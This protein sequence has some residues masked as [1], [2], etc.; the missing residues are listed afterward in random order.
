M[1]RTAPSACRGLFVDSGGVGC[2][3]SEECGRLSANTLYA[4]PTPRSSVIDLPL[5]VLWDAISPHEADE[6]GL[7]TEN[8]R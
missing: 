3:D 8:L 7:N 5:I 2:C 6:K 1:G 4:T